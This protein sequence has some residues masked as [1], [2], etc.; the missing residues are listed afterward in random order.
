MKKM[1]NYDFENK[2]IIG[3]NS[4]IKRANKGVGREYVELCKMIKDHPDFDIVPKD[5][6]RKKNK[7][8]Y[9]GLTFE[10][11]EDY[12]M[13]QPDSENKLKLFKKIKDVAEAKGAKYPLTKKWFLKTYPEYKENES[14]VMSEATAQEHAEA[15][16]EALIDEDEL[17]A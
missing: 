11:M 15:E 16:I 7:K 10:R 1:F 14:V 12:I 2:T 5:I 4:A 3:S 13:T 6:D 9:S 17:V 8:K